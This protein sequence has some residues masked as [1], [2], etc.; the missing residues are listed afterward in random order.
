VIDLYDNHTIIPKW[1][2][3]MKVIKENNKQLRN[4]HRITIYVGQGKRKELLKQVME[5]TQASSISEA[6]FRVLTEFMRE[7]EQKQ[8]ERREKVAEKTKGIW[9]NN[10][11]VD[12]AFEEVDKRWQTWKIEEY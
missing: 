2:I 5:Y 4:Y 12:K 7:R 6:I 1:V 11:G 9:A 8:K 3:I 10:L